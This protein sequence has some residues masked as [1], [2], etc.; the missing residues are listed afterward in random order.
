MKSH[1]FDMVLYNRYQATEAFD[2]LASLLPEE[3]AKLDSE[4]I[5]KSVNTDKIL[6]KLFSEEGLKNPRIQSAYYV[7]IIDNKIKLKDFD[8]YKKYRGKETNYLP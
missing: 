6:K 2:F 3:K 4:F 8:E 1:F 5:K 7:Y